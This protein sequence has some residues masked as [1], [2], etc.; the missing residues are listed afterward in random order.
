MDP[1]PLHAFVDLCNFFLNL[2]P[3]LGQA[4]HHPDGTF[5]ARK[6]ASGLMQLFSAR[7]LSMSGLMMLLPMQM[8]FLHLRRKKD[9][10]FRSF[11]NT[12]TMGI[13]QRER[14]ETQSAGGKPLS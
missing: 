10:Q 4:T 2:S 3:I 1:L 14:T 8:A 11:N 5:I 7:N 13:N 9:R 12:M 6:E